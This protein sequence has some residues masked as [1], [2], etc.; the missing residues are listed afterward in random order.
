MTQRERRLFL[1]SATATFAVGCALLYVHHEYA[2]AYT[3]PSAGG[4]AVH[5]TEPYIDSPTRVKVNAVVTRTRNTGEGGSF[6]VRVFVGDSLRRTASGS[7]G[8][9]Q[10]SVILPV[11][12]PCT[13]SRPRAWWAVI[14]GLSRGRRSEAVSRIIRLGCK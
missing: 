3:S 13:R 7:I 11:E 9:R 1:R 5:V 10:T 8:P 14:N 12:A 4:I 6:T 2:E